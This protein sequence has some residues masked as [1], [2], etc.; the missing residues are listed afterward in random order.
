MGLQGDMAVAHCALSGAVLP[1]V[2]GWGREGGEGEGMVWCCRWSLALA[3][4][5]GRRGGQ[6]GGG[7][8]WW[9]RME[10]VLK[11][12]QIDGLASALLFELLAL[13]LAGL[14]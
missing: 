12:R 14:A 10:C 4:G 5:S 7:A 8:Q 1:W 13:A 2:R 9:H 11:Q 6:R 3:Y